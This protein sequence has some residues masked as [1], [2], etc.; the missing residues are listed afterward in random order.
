MPI[1]TISY[2]ELRR[3]VAG[4]MGGG[5]VSGDIDSGGVTTIVDNTTHTIFGSSGRADEYAGWYLLRPDSIGASSDTLDR[6]RRVQ[7][8]DPSTGTIHTVG[9]DYNDTTFT[10]E[11]YEL[12]P[13]LDPDNG[14]NGMLAAINN[15]LTRRLRY[16]TTVPLTLAADGDMDLSGITNWTAANL[17]TTAKDTGAA[18][19]FQG[20]RSLHAVTNAVNGY[21]ASDAINVREG[22]GYYIEAIV[23]S[24]DASSTPK[25]VVVDQSGNEIDSW[26][27]ADMGLQADIY[28]D[29]VS[30]GRTVFQPQ[31]GD[32][33]IVVRLQGV[34]NGADLYWDSVIVLRQAQREFVLPTW[35]E[36][37]TQLQGIFMPLGSF[38]R[39][40][41]WH[42][43]AEADHKIHLD[44]AA[45]NFGILRMQ[46]RTTRRIYIRAWRPYDKI[47]ITTSAGDDDAIAVPE[48]WAIEACLVEAY[49][50]LRQGNGNGRT[51][52]NLDQE[53]LKAQRRTYHLV[54]H[55]MRPQPK[56]FPRGPWQE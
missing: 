15:A 3:K 30:L 20:V 26:T 18:N 16:L 40:W 44:A 19:V 29:W 25:L 34:E 4:R 6:V 39:T 45:A 49:E 5:F 1:T 22:E 54:R 41:A 42:Q 36:D 55:Y 37:E 27:P 10:S 12:H 11:V 43:L 14:D 38:P 8:H 21:A 33:S 9:P 28:T 53:L 48:D 47:T 35:V 50:L 56:P 32:T 13:Y 24:A 23:R 46:H 51:P 2:Q 17:G 52:Q 31:A 7:R